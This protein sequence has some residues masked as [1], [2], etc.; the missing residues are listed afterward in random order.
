[1]SDIDYG[2]EKYSEDGDYIIVAREETFGS[3]VCH[4]PLTSASGRHWPSRRARIVA[5]VNALEGYNPAAVRDVVEALRGFIEEYG[6]R[7]RDDNSLLFPE[8]QEELVETAMVS[9]A[10]LE[11]GAA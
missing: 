3:I 10:R 8:Y 1:M 7:H 4:A 6:K 9:L 5:C 11:G 2:R